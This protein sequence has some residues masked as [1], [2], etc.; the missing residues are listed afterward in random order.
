MKNARQSRLRFHFFS[1]VGTVPG[2]ANDD[3]AQEDSSK[4]VLACCKKTRVS[5]FGV[6]IGGNKCPECQPAGNAAA[7]NGN[8]Q[9]EER[10]RQLS[11]GIIAIAGK[12]DFTY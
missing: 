7:D 9:N 4:H 2:H 5:F 12:E 6:G 11:Q 3:D 8:A 10:S 1:P